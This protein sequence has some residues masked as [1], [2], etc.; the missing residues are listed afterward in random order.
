MARGGRRLRSNVLKG[1]FVGRR[2]LPTQ[3]NPHACIFTRS[4]ILHHMMNVDITF[5]YMGARHFY[6]S[7]A[8]FSHGLRLL[9]FARSLPPVHYIEVVITMA[10]SRQLLISALALTLPRHI[11]AL[12]PVE[13]ELLAPTCSSY[14]SYNATTNIAG[15]WKVVADSTGTSI[16]G[17][18][19]SIVSFTNDGK[20][21]YGFVRPLSLLEH[22]PS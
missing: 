15:P 10:T 11:S 1:Q 6:L 16:D 4:S 12:P 14:P 8:A 22:V 9:A 7:L 20:D 3:W 18:G 2:T 13:I 21:R 5:G 19:A 17:G